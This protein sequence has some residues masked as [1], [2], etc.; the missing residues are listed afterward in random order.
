MEGAP[1]VDVSFPTNQL[2]QP[3]KAI[4][5]RSDH[6]SRFLTFLLI[7]PP[8]GRPCFAKTEQKIPPGDYQE[9]FIIDDFPEGG[10]RTAEGV[11]RLALPVKTESVGLP[12]CFSSGPTVPAGSR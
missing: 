8:T 7:C 10:H 2:L 11:P 9:P 3:A 5:C 12:E 6:S 1:S 4:T